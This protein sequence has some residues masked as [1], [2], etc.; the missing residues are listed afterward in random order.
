VTNEQ[1][2][3]ARKIDKYIYKYSCVKSKVRMFFH[4]A[5]WRTLYFLKL[6]RAYSVFACKHNF[7]AKIEL[8]GVC[9]WCGKVH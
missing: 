8:T 1:C 4:A 7:Y 3:E 6:A 9:H 5:F 2:C